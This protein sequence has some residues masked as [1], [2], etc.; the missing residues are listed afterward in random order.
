MKRIVFDSSSIISLTNNCFFSFFE[1]LKDDVN[2]ELLIGKGV[3]DETVSSALKSKKF[4][5]QA[6][7]INHL[8]NSGIFTLVKDKNLDN[9]T[10]TFLG[11][12]NNLLFVNNQGVKIIQYG[13]AECVAIHKIKPVDLFIVDERTT[14]YLLE[15]LNQLKNLIEKRLH[16]PVR[17][18]PKMQGE[19]DSYFGNVAI[20]RSTELI[21]YGFEKNYFPGLSKDKRFLEGLLWSLKLSGCAI[22]TSEI[23]SYL[24]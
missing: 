2:A 20:G 6:Y 1:H 13:E 12:S 18:N 22:N 23:D 21:K 5:V 11:V 7:R 10:K 3:Y 4:R 24:K 9:E 16:T 17:L 19:L 8:V 15:D 14:R